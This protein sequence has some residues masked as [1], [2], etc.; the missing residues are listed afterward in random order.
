MVKYVVSVLD[1]DKKEFIVEEHTTEESA[2]AAYTVYKQIQK[3][4]PDFYIVQIKNMSF[5][6]KKQLH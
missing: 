3:D 2:M 4:D 6:D 5:Y 1:E